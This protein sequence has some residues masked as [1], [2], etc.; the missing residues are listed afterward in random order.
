V[1][2]SAGQIV[3]GDVVIAISN[4]GRTQELIAAVGAVRGLGAKVIAIAGD[5][6]SPLA[7][8]ADVVLDASVARE[9][10]GHGQAPRAS[11]AA[12]LLV[13]TTLSAGLETA[14]GFTR[15]EYH[16]RHPAG[17]LGEMSKKK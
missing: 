4:S 11:I 14:R 13:L 1:H 8:V 7:K 10:G 3:P 6:A 12:E 16:A 15:E 5:V 2:G 17:R 9:G